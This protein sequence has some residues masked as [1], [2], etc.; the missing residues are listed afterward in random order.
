M[1]AK[2]V[3]ANRQC[4]IQPQH[5]PLRHL[6]PLP[7]AHTFSTITTQPINTHYHPGAPFDGHVYNKEIQKAV[8]DGAEAE[9]C[10]HVLLLRFR[11]EFLNDLNGFP[12]AASAFV[13]MYS[14]VR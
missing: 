10:H 13:L 7:S 3:K 14:A 11:E 5:P 12:V 8:A 1:G 4:L 9:R 2:R 6:H